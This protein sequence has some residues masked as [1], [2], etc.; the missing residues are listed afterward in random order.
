MCKYIYIY[1]YNMTRTKIWGSGANKKTR[2]PPPILE[3]DFF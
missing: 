2:F 1:I 3:V